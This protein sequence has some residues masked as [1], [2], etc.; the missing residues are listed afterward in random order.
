MKKEFSKN[1]N[2]SKQPRKKRK[3]LAKAPIHLKKKFLSTTLSKELRKKYKKRN[4][5]LRKGDKIKILKG[6]HKGKTGKVNEIKI[7]RL[8]VYIDGIQT[9]K[10]DGSKVNI[11]LRPSNLQIIELNLDD[12]KRLA[13]ISAN[14]K[15]KEKINEDKK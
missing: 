1:W 11:P 12:K 3:Y 2:S 9:K 13:K 5:V 8:K 7:K 14:S 4:V 15:N 6:K 10:Q